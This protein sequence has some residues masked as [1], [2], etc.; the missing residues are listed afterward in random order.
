MKNTPGNIPF[1]SFSRINS[2]ERNEIFEQFKKVYDSQYYVLGT[3]VKQFEEQFA[4]YCGTHYCVGVGNGLDALFLSLTALDIGRGD[5][6]ILPS[7]TYIATVLAVSYVGATPVFV[8]PNEATFNINYKNIETAITSKTKA[9]IPVHLYGQA[10]EMKQIMDI[11]ERHSLFVIEDNAQS[12][13]AMNNN[14][15]TGSFGTLNCT[16]FYPAKNI[17]ALGDAGAINTNDEKLKV[18][19]HELRNYGS[20]VKYVNDVIGYNSRLDEL[21]A[22]FLSVKLKYLEQWNRE[23]QEVAAIY[24]SLLK[25]VGDILLPAVADN[26][27]SV[28]HQFVIRTGKRNLLMEH[29]NKNGI[30]TL[31]HYPIPPHLQKAYSHLKYVKGDFPIAETMA[32]TCLSLPVYPGLQKNEAE[33]IAETM[34]AFY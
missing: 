26:S 13:G 5:E 34:K 23:R 30:G 1:F 18:K 14:K 27:T 10:C 12:Q 21:Q 19:L 16:S 11:A 6:V 29:L 31:I 33:F 22:A 28:Y 4:A 25:G 24:N 32:D 3:S 8:E 15:R 9:I 2:I 7:N 17:G 20:K